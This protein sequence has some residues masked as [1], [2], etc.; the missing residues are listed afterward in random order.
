MF[1]AFV[2]PPSDEFESY[3]FFLQ[4]VCFWC[5][6]QVPRELYQPFIYTD[7]AYSGQNML[8]AIKQLRFA[9]TIGIPQVA[10]ARVAIAAG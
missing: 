8:L 5:S 9:S 4:Y 7:L 3:M 10:F 1:A 6:F 2:T